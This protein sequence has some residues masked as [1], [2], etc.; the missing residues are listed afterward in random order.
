MFLLTLPR[1]YSLVV[2]VAVAVAVAVAGAGA[3][4]VAV[5][6]AVAV[7]VVLHCTRLTGTMIRRK[8]GIARQL[9]WLHLPLEILLALAP[10]YI[11]PR[12]PENK[13]LRISCM[14]AIYHRCSSC[15]CHLIIAVKYAA[16]HSLQQ[17]SP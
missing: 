11:A 3:G 1:S 10:S 4:G 16:I 7:V 5:A 14:H 13:R 9:C 12:R 8:A 6:V 17:L 2:V 15:P